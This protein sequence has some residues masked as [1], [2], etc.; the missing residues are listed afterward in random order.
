MTSVHSKVL[1]IVKG[2]SLPKRL[3]THGQETVEVYTETLKVR[4]EGQTE[5]S[6]M[7]I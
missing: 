3:G 2:S 4:P 1:W 7:V 6:L 5:E